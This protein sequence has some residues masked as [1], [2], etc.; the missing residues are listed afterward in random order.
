MGLRNES[1]NE[2][3]IISNRVLQVGTPRVE[4]TIPNLGDSFMPQLG[5]W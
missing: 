1:E 2:G 3:I 4:Y 5:S